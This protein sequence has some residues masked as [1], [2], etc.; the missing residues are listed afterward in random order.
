MQL[1][2][3]PAA[4]FS[5]FAVLAL[6]IAASAAFAA[7]EKKAED[8]AALVNGEPIIS[9]AVQGEVNGILRRY[10]SQGQKPNEAEMAS[11]K[12]SA[13]EK[14][15][16]LELLN[17]ASKKA[18]IAVNN[19]DVES[20]LAGYKK[21]FADEKEFAKAIAEAGLNEAE[22]KKQIVKNF[23]IQKYIDS[24]FKGKVKVT[25]QDAKEFYTSNKEKFEQ[26]EMVHARHIL[27]LS[28]EGD[29]KAD[30]NRKREK[31][32]QIKKEL[33]GG[34]DFTELA[35]K[36]SEGPSKE[37]GGDLGF[38]A[39]G[40]MVKPFEQVAFSMMPGDVSDI[41]ETE[42]GYHLIKMEEKRP[43]KTVT[44]EESKVKITNYLSQE[45]LNENIETYLKEARAKADVKITGKQAAK[46]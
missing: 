15:I 46:K 45:K 16:K 12:E 10:Y 32:M 25:D 22:L 30:K 2:K 43:A 21:G 38:F 40:Q 42:F 39:R 23:A 28:K 29:S 33:K 5:L 35:K 17:Q 14:L 41:V 26:P 6:G 13:L 1:K 24:Q 36:F 19:A 11:I 20:E 18:G 34:A 27:L 9:A 37:Q 7:P 4:V 8:V 44:F 31:L 3:I